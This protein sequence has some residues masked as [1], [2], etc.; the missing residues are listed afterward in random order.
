MR[1]LF[2]V[3]QC[4]GICISTF[5]EFRVSHRVVMSGNPLVAASGI[6]G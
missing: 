2:G 3:A 6:I 4:L 1:L 5:E